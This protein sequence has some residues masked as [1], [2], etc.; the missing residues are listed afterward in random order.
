[1]P[2][3]ILDGKIVAAEIKREVSAETAQL[4]A[5][6][7]F[8]PLLAVVRVGSDPASVVYVK[9]KI[10]TSHEIGILSEEHHLD[11]SI[12]EEKLL[13]L[14]GELNHRADVDGILVQLPLPKHINETAVL[15]SVSP[16]KDV[17]GF[18]PLNAGRLSQG[19][20]ILVPCTPAGI[21]EM[22]VRCNIEVRGKRAVVVGRSNI[23][24]RPMAQLLLNAS[25][26]VTIC[27]SA[28][29]DLYEHTLRADILVV[30]VG[31]AAMIR[32]SHIK[33]GAAVIDVGM[34]RVEAESV[35]RELFA[36]AEWDKR[37][38]AVRSKGFTLTGDVHPREAAETAGALT[39]VPGGVGL[40]TVSMLM[41][42][43]VIAASRRREF[44]SANSMTKI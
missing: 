19:H 42:N 14:V 41:K 26:T 24:G 8:R 34:N 40:L 11:E 10:K 12:S 20:P 28:T 17:D 13:G 33:P 6:F 32:A 31:S 21:M 9:N 23:V 39:P 44:R 16:E 25:A 4:Y 36:E 15:E 29:T 38:A 35:V 2:A 18:H 5:D 22:L 37:T 27:H 3:Q 1:M 30:A 7:G 43:T